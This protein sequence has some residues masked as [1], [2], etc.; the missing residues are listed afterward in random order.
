M[1]QIKKAQYGTVI[2]RIDSLT[3]ENQ[4]LLYNPSTP[5]D[6]KEQA[7]KMVQ[8]YQNRVN[9]G[10]TSYKEML[11]DKERFA[12]Q[13]NAF[14]K[15]NSSF[16]SPTAEVTSEQ[17]S[18]P[19]NV[20]V[21]PFATFNPTEGFN[22]YTTPTDTQDAKIKQ[23][24]SELSR[25]LNLFS[26]KGYSTD[27]NVFKGI[28]ADSYKDINTYVQ[29]LN[30]ITNKLT[31]DNN[32]IKKIGE[33]V[34]RL[35]NDDLHSLY[36][37]FF[38]DTLHPTDTNK[39]TSSTTT[40]ATNDKESDKY[41]GLLKVALPDSAIAYIQLDPTNSEYQ[42]AKIVKN[43]QETTYNLADEDVLNKLGSTAWS[44]IANAIKIANKNKYQIG[45][46]SAWGGRDNIIDFSDYFP[47]MTKTNED[48]SV[49]ADLVLGDLSKDPSF[50]FDTS[51]WIPYDKIIENWENIK[52]DFHFAGGADI[53]PNGNS[54]SHQYADSLGVVEGVDLSNISSADQGTIN[55]IFVGS[56]V[57][58]Q[59]TQN[60]L[61]DPKNV[62][63]Y[64][65]LSVA[66]RAN[67]LSESL[68][69][70]YTQELEAYRFV[71]PKFFKEALDRASIEDV[72]SLAAV[73]IKNAPDTFSKQAVAYWLK[74]F[75]NA[76]GADSQVAAKK[77][78]GTLKFQQG[79]YENWQTEQPSN[80]LQS[81]T[82]SESA[83]KSDQKVDKIRDTENSEGFQW[84]TEDT[85]RTLSLM[86]DLAGGFSSNAVGLGTAV[87]LGTGVLSTLLD[88]TADIVD[89]SVTDEERRNTALFNTGATVV[90]A[91]PDAKFLTTGSKALKFI[92]KIAKRAGGLAQLAGIIGLG[93]QDVQR[94]S[95]LRNSEPN[96]FKSED[97]RLI[98]NTLQALYGIRKAGFANIKGGKNNR[99]QAAIS[100]AITEKDRVIPL[101]NK[102]GEMENIPV[103][104][105]TFNEIIQEGRSKGTEAANKL[106]RE[107]LGNKVADDAEIP[108]EFGDNKFTRWVQARWN[109][110]SEYA[111]FM[112][113]T[114]YESYRLPYNKESVTNI[115]NSPKNTGWDWWKNKNG[116][117]AG[118]EMNYYTWGNHNKDLGIPSATKSRIYNTP[119][120]GAAAHSATPA[121]PAT[122]RS[123]RSS[124]SSRHRKQNG[125]KLLKLQNYINYGKSDI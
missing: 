67:N 14:L 55:N 15:G 105:S 22:I 94:L 40:A 95:E 111:G 106:M 74:D 77:E 82:E 123:S 63:N 112:P 41:K 33:I 61:F 24:A 29:Q 73:A 47:G 97:L 102:K 83:G 79:S 8:D 103:S 37:E 30:A 69:K 6:R 57:S 53:D 100:K 81:S 3:R 5:S 1:A 66:S 19:I 65:R 91:I 110:L 118:W 34:S 51:V 60:G 64:L 98:F 35:N 108:I 119:A 18:T 12:Q 56:Q 92:A 38:T 26:Q 44:T 62:A 70:S 86:S 109:N 80:Y 32:D 121:T 50:N 99:K 89:K 31:T 59:F 114:S 124:R 72:K 76:R 36:T 104:E 101:K 43:G 52:K 27:N 107:R 71:S 42:F 45:N 96:S 28:S 115:L 90:G 68:K 20:K 125:G 25:S 88:Y 87:S 13:L 2:N 4:N 122:S 23:F 84:K 9:Q 21:R 11:Q 39:G 17:A 75:L 113:N 10:Y 117:I 7:D 85:L 46:Y 58:K 54:T 16:E 120:Y 116:N 93:A 48:G 49:T 78:G